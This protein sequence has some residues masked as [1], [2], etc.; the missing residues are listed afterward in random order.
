M[1]FPSQFVKHFQKDRMAT[2]K[3]TAPSTTPLVALVPITHDGVAYAPGDALPD[4]EQISADALLAAGAAK[5]ADA[6][7]AA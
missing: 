5:A 2:S 3:K 4:M 7:A 1:G 6:T